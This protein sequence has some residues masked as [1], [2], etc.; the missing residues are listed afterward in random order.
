MRDNIRVLYLA[1]Y[2]NRNLS[3]CSS[4][5]YMKVMLPILL[6]NPKVYLYLPVPEGSDFD[7]G[8]IGLDHPRVMKI[9]MKF[10]VMEY[11]SLKQ[12]DE[13]TKIQPEYIPNF[14]DFGGKYYIDAVI[15]DKPE[16]LVT[17]KNIFSSPYVTSCIPPV[18][19][20][21]VQYALGADT[22]KKFQDSLFMAQSMGLAQADLISFVN[23]NSQTRALKYAR[24]HLAPSYVRQILDRSNF[25]LN[26]VNIERMEKFKVAEKPKSPMIVSYG[27][28]LNRVYRFEDLFEIF[29]KLFCS[30]RDVKVLINTNSASA[31]GWNWDKYEKHFQIKVDC[32]QEEFY[33]DIATAHA[34]L[35]MATEFEMSY[36]ACEKS[37]LGLVGVFLDSPRARNI[38]YP[39]YP[40]LCKGKLELATALRYVLEH[41][42][43]DDVQ[44]VIKKQNE[45]ILKNYNGIR[46]AED[47]VFKIREAVQKRDDFYFKHYQGKKV[48]LNEIFKDV[49]EIDYEGFKKKI[50]DGTINGIDIEW[51]YGRY[52]LS[53]TVWRGCMEMIG[54]EDNCQGPDPYFVR[55]RE[56]NPDP[57]IVQEDVD[58]DNDTNEL[59]LDKDY[60]LGS[61]EV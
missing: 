54:F 13:M 4:V 11:A 49:K 45:F 1:L 50:H 38:V 47:F 5:N 55:V 29:D 28:G 15:V 18:F 59:E 37:L 36:S 12:I 33:R 3:R 22:H 48:L 35:F 19:I 17:W 8:S 58:K 24:Q 23:A 6:K 60:D 14:E 30:G 56:Y 57:T 51:D 44:I 40:Y 27:Y 53:R 39:G 43:E 7:W 26:G 31:F 41:Y 32:P 42:F 34:F 46:N 52:A 25:Y 2:T 10:G 21:N 61:K 9:P 20:A 16:V